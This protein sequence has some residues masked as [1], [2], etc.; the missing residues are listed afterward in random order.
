MMWPLLGKFL[1]RSPSHSHS[2]SFTTFKDVQTLCKE[3][4]QDDDDDKQQK[5]QHHHHH[6]QDKS[7]KNGETH[8][9]KSSAIFHRVRIATTA[10]RAWNSLLPRPHQQPNRIVVYFTS[11]RVVRKTFEDCR[12]VRSIL[13]G[14]R[15]TV[16]ERDLSMDAGFLDELK[17]LLGDKQLALPRVFIGG[18]YIGGADEIVYLHE[19]GELKKIV[20]GFPMAKLGACSGCGGVRFVLCFDCSGSR[21]VYLEDEEEEGG[22]R[23]CFVCNENGLIR[24]PSCC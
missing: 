15:I 16:D 17:A 9:T 11:L 7:R 3:E 21:K 22:F 19:T 1:R 2:F 23:M 13:Q 18:R 24:C 4:V 12:T 8:L 6:H 10:L 14:F 5:Q 20:Q